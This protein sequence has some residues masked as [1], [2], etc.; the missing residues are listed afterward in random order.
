MEMELPQFVD[1][2]GKTP[3]EQWRQAVCPNPFGQG[4]DS[5]D[6]I[7]KKLLDPGTFLQAFPVTVAFALPG[8]QVSDSDRERC[9]R[10]AHVIFKRELVRAW[11]KQARTRQPDGREQ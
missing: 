10:E 4:R 6:A 1:M 3:G 2:L 8:G 9:G 7:M 5:L 11:G